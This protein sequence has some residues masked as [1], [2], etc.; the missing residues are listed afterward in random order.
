[1]HGYA[2]TGAALTFIFF[3]AWEARVGARSGC[4]VATVRRA[5]GD[6]RVAMAIDRDRHLTR[7]CAEPAVNGMLRAG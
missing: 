6:T 3:G 2:V 5:L 4:P 1:M 7:A